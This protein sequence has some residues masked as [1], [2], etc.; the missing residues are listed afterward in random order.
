MFEF[1]IKTG[2][3]KIDH[4]KCVQCDT[5]ACVKACSLFGSNILRLVDTKPFLAPSL[6][7][8]K[9]GACIEDLSCELYCWKDGK[10]ALTIELPIPKLAE[11]RSK[12]V[13]G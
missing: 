11:F 4:R 12:S 6:E 9:K 13:G 1:E 2:T 3:I 7:D 5:K 10:Q 8:T